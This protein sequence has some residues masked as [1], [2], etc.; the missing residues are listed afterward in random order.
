MM[1]DKDYIY[2]LFN[3]VLERVDVVRAMQAG[4]APPHRPWQETPSLFERF[5]AAVRLASVKDDYVKVVDLSKW[6]IETIQQLIDMGFQAGIIKATQNTFTDTKFDIYVNQAA[7]LNFPIL[8]YH[9]SDPAGRPA[10]EQA[11]YFCNVTDG[12]GHGKFDDAE[13]TGNLSP[14]AL[15]YWH[16]D[17]MGETSVHTSQRKGIYTRVSWW[18]GRVAPS[19]WAADYDLWVARWAE[20]LEGP[21]SDGKYVPRDWTDWVMW[22]YKSPG[23]DYNYFQGNWEQFQ[24]Y[25][26]LV[27]END[28]CS[29]LKHMEDDLAVLK[30]ILNC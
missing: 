4:D 10:V 22:Q 23:L 2:E 5:A 30:G 24:K 29:I 13:W 1:E 20:W 7:V 21:W 27:P 26:G 19:P 14:T 9:F 3:G 8:V 28:V 18:D 12:I 6:D 15:S 17:F 11:K 16:R 25:Y